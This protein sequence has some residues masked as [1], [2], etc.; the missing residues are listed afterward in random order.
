MRTLF[1]APLVILLTAAAGYVACR[2]M[3]IDPH[4]GAMITAAVIA[5]LAC[6]AALVPM[7][8]TRGADQTAVVQAGLVATVAHLFA[9]V[10]L[11]AAAILKFKAGQPFAYWMMAMYWLTLVVVVIA[12]VRELKSAA[13]APSSSAAPRH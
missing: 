8:L 4:T 11:A 2:A 13:P 5:A 12:T 10:A 7:W 9:T 1:L 3:S 6:G